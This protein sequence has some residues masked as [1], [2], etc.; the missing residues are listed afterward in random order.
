M[1]RI[2]F[3][4][5]VILHGLI[6]IIGFAKALKPDA[7]DVLAIGISK[8]AGVLWLFAALLFMST[9]VALL[10]QKDWWWILSV[11]AL[12]FSQALI[13]FNWQAAKAGTIANGVIFIVTIV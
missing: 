1:L 8:Y 6:H 9:A 12:I 7:V 3:I 13:F 5:I 11:T 10:F 4:T 2:V